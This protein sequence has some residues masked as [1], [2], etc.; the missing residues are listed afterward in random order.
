M[1][2]ARVQPEG[3]ARRERLDGVADVEPA[4]AAQDPDDLVVEVVVPWRTS[5]RDVA[6]EHRRAGRA[7]VRPVKDLERPRA[8]RRARLDVLELDDGLDGPH[9]RVQVGRR[10]ERGPDAREP[11]GAGE[12]RAGQ[13]GGHEAARSAAERCVV[14]RPRARVGEEERVVK[15]VAEVERRARLEAQRVERELRAARRTGRASVARLRRRQ[16][17][18]PRPVARPDPCARA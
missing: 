1:H 8:G 15:L 18:P 6:D 4:L 16:A 7:V 9:R 12:E 2:L 14:K 10:T 17:G 11:V 3:A 13:A 5:R